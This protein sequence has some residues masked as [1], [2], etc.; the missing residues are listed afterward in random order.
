MPRPITPRTDYFK[1][2]QVLLRIARSVSE[3]KEKDPE[4]KSAVVDRLFEAAKLIMSDSLDALKA[5]GKKAKV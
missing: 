5:D 3:D 2:S 1:E 4:W